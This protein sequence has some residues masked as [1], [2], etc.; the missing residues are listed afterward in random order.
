MYNC[1]KNFG[2]VSSLTTDLEGSEDPRSEN[3]FVRLSSSGQ[4]LLGMKSTS[5]PSP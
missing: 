5:S 4:G 3:A 1:D 2:C